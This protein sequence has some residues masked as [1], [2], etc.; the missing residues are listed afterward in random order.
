MTLAIVLT[1][2]GQFAFAQPAPRDGIT[3]E[4]PSVLEAQRTEYERLIV[5]ARDEVVAWFGSV[6]L[7]VKAADMIDRAVVYSDAGT[8]R[9]AMAE[10]FKIDMQKIPDTFGGTVNGKTLYINS[11]ETFRPMWT[12]LYPE[13]PWSRKSYRSLM[14]HELAHRAHAHLSFVRA[15]SE[16]AMGPPWFFEGLAVMCAGQFAAGEKPMGIVEILS[17]VGEGKTP[18]VSYPHY[19]RLI[20]SLS[21]FV[22]VRSL[23]EEAAEPGF[24]RK[25]LEADDKGKASVRETSRGEPAAAGKQERLKK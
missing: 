16:D 14:V 20:R 23:V 3:V 24:P 11:E 21:Q 7:P 1:L 19:G 12:K 2:G 5:S 17:D 15:G 13:W 10:L 4:L 8:S 6:G 22:S 25:L 18:K 9:R